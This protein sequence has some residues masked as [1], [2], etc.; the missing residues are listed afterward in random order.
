M[1]APTAQE[2]RAVVIQW[3]REPGRP[4]LPVLRARLATL[5]TDARSSVRLTVENVAGSLTLILY[6][7][8]RDVSGNVIFNE[9][10]TATRDQLGSRI[11]DFNDILDDTQTTRRERGEAI[12][13]L[14]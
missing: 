13:S 4:L 10:R 1:A 2:V 12:Q 9:T 5:W 8:R 3:W 11:E 7:E 6:L 14:R